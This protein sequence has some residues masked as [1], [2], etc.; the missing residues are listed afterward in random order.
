MAD[1]SPISVQ[2]LS[3]R[4]RSV[5]ESDDLQRCV[6]FYLAV[7]RRELSNLRVWAVDGTMRPSGPV[8][9]FYLRQLALSA[10]S[11]VAGMQNVI[12]DVVVPIPQPHCSRLRDDSNGEFLP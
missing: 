2:D 7:V 6:A 3:R 8:I 1:T 12:D 11:R 4:W 10:A 5:C 9:S